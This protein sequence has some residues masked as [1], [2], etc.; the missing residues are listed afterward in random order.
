MQ[1]SE[2]ENHS[3][4][5][6]GREVQFTLRRSAR[7]KRIKL[8]V[9]LAAG[10]EVVIPARAMVS[11]SK[12][13]GFIRE[14]QRW[15]LKHLTKI[16][17]VSEESSSKKSL[18]LFLGREV[19]IKVKESKRKTP[20][21]FPENGS[22]TVKVPIG[23]R[24]M[25][26][27]AITA[28]YKKQAAGIIPKVVREKSALMLAFP[29]RI[30]IRDQRTRWGSCSSRGTLSFSWRL[31]AA[32]RSVIEYV[33]VHELAHLKHRN[34]SKAFW[35]EVESYCSEYK[36]AEKWLRENKHI[37]RARTTFAE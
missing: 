13:E 1:S 18:L 9:S 24:Q 27:R 11:L 21:A 34:H 31:V 20:R 33:A 30:S 7:A 14:K 6:A 19:P 23:K 37:L 12:V 17:K 29:K 2:N 35:H 15:V 36:Q 26:G 4:L 10:L 8:Q 16:E 25:A 22:L 32:P 28:F 5:L 3:I